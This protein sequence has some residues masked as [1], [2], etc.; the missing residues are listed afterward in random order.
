[1]IS[2]WHIFVQWYIYSSKWKCISLWENSSPSNRVWRMRYATSIKLTSA[3]KQR[4]LTQTRNVLPDWGQIRSCN[5]TDARLMK[6]CRSDRRY[7]A[8]RFDFVRD[9]IIATTVNSVFERTQY[10]SA[11][12]LLSDVFVK[13]SKF[14][15]C[16]SLRRSIFQEQALEN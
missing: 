8:E 12:L 16:K 13:V 1:M 9:S 14:A 15:R 3:C 10:S 4:D 11:I 7:F 5:F 6:Q 2:E